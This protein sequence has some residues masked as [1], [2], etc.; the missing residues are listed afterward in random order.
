[1][2]D[3]GLDPLV[4]ERP[5][6]ALGHCTAFG[7]NIIKNAIISCCELE[8][9]RDMVCW[10]ACILTSSAAPRDRVWT[11]NGALEG[12]GPVA[13]R[14]GGVG[15]DGGRAHQID[16][17]LVICQVRAYRLVAL[18]GT[19]RMALR[20]APECDRARSRSRSKDR[21]SESHR[22]AAG[23][24]RPSC[25]AVGRVAFDQAGEFKR[26]AP[27]FSALSRKSWLK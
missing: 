18:R 26:R 27:A 12:L 24:S 3:L 15:R 6:V 14:V 20:R 9:P 2:P 10:S 25:D 21:R 17:M 16:L 19:E 11:A 22:A 7:C 4:R 23:T 8:S 5:L 1:M 13:L